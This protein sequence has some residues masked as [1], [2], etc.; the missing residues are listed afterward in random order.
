VKNVSLIGKPKSISIKQETLNTKKRESTQLV[1]L[2][3]KV[4][5]EFHRAFKIYAAANDMSMKDV[6]MAAFSALKEKNIS[7]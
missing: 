7:G 4:S 6:L 1:D 2:N 3:F 5:A